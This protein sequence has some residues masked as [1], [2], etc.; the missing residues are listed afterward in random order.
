MGSRS[1][2]RAVSFLYAL[3]SWNPSWRS[4][5]QEALKHSYFRTAKPTTIE[6]PGQ[7]IP[8]GQGKNDEIL[9]DWLI[10]IN[11]LIFLISDSGTVA[12]RPKRQMTLHL[13]TGKF[14]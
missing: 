9:E 10:C 6:D 12:L 13:Q 14:K 1:S 4:T 5:A 2:A 7:I 11:V 3:L 8:S